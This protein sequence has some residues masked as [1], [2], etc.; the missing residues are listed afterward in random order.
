MKIIDEKAT[1]VLLAE[2][3]EEIDK[4]CLELQEKKREQK[5]KNVFFFSCFAVSLIFLLQTFFKLMSINFILFFFI[6][7]VTALAFVIPVILNMNKG[8]ITK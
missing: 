5:L 4:K 3:D 8:V 6:F 1:E 7:Q 2:L